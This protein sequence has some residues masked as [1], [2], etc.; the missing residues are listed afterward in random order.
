MPARRDRGLDEPV[1]RHGRRPV[2]PRAVQRFGVGHPCGDQ[3]GRRGELEDQPQPLLVD[4]G[5]LRQPLDVTHAEAAAAKFGNRCAAEGFED[6]LDF[7]QQVDHRAGRDRV[8]VGGGGR[9]HHGVGRGQRDRSGCLAAQ[10]L[11]DQSRQDHGFRVDLPEQTRGQ[12]PLH[13]PVGRGAGRRVAGPAHRRALHQ[14]PQQI[15]LWRRPAPRAVRRSRRRCALPLRGRPGRDTRAGPP[16]PR[17]PPGPR[18]RPTPAPARAGR[19]GRRR[20]RPHRRGRRSGRSAWSAARAWFRH[21]ASAAH[22]APPAA[23][24]PARRWRP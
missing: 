20:R 12:Q 15:P 17:R 23:E 21:A 10:H 4:A 24:S 19:R 11:T 1:G 16:R 5:Q 8:D 13:G 6:Q 7:T 18:S 22:R 3:P 2:R 9:R 14:A